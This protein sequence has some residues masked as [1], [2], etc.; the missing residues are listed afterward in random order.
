MATVVDTQPTFTLGIAGTYVTPM[1]K[2][3]TF[4]LE[5]KV[6]ETRKIIVGDGFVN[7][8][9]T[10]IENFYL[11]MIECASAINVRFTNT[12]VVITP[13]SSTTSV[14]SFPVNAGMPLMLPL[15]QAFVAGLD[16]IS[17]STASTTDVQVYIRAYG[18]VITA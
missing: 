10:N 13:P 12:V 11:L 16:S 5:N 17:I 1:N 18:K 7:L 8:D 9:F 15:T 14:I 3:F 4:A 2:T 6:E